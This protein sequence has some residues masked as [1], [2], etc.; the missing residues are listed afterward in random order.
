MTARAPRSQEE[1]ETLATFGRRLRVL[2]LWYG[3]SEAEMADA[4]GVSVRSL[5]GRE[6][7]TL[8]SRGLMCLA[9]ELGETFNVSIDWMIGHEISA[10]Y[11][12]ENRPV[13][14]DGQPMKLVAYDPIRILV[15]KAYREADPVG[16]AALVRA[17][18][19]ISENMP[20]ELVEELFYLE[21]SGAD[22]EAIAALQRQRWRIITNGHR[23]RNSDIV[24]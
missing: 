24:E 18:R 21:R 14:S 1:E 4:L 20:V 5:K 7:G 3:L 23:A 13:G 17:C 15:I 6:A 10:A 8:G 2:R 16:K 22:P 19:R 9:V 11:G 12:D